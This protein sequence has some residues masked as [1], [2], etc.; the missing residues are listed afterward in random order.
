MPWVRVCS[1]SSVASDSLWLHALQPARLLCPWGSPGKDTGEGGHA[2]LQ[3]IF[4][5]QV[6]CISFWATGVAHWCHI[7][8]Y[9]Q[10]GTSK[11]RAESLSCCL[12][13]N[14]NTWEDVNDMPLILNPRGL[15]CMGPLICV[16]FPE[17][18][19][20]L[21]HSPGTGG[22]WG[23]RTLNGGSSDAEE[24]QIQ[25]PTRNYSGLQLPEE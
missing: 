14:V 16:F 17:V 21:L 12:R 1:A 8:W 23:C 22:M 25:G 18:N 9:H 13:L 19:A 3:G 4:P 6:S 20:A 2:L 5:T 10:V 11:L 7:L 15:G 24:T